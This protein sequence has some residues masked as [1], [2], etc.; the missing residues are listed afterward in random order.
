MGRGPR[1]IDGALGS[2][3]GA[4][5][6]LGDGAAMETPGDADDF[7]SEHLLNRADRVEVFPKSFGEFAVFGGFFGP[8]TVLGGEEAELEVVARRAGLTRR[9]FGTARTMRRLS[10]WLRIARQMPWQ[11]SFSAPE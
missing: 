5:F 4:I 9:S 1:A 7:D 2:G 11:I 3:I 8:D 10:D 6:G